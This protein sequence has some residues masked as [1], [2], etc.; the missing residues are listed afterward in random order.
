MKAGNVWRIKFFTAQSVAIVMLLRNT[1]DSYKNVAV[2]A[3]LCL[4][5]SCAK[6][7]PGPSGRLE[8]HS[9]ESQKWAGLRLAGPSSV[10]GGCAFA[11]KCSP[12]YLHQSPLLLADLLGTWQRGATY[13]PLDPTH[14]NDRNTLM[15]EDADDDFVLSETDVL[16]SAPRGSAKLLAAIDDW[17]ISSHQQRH[18]FAQS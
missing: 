5:S 13:L 1:S 12:I 14:P 16:P 17:G 6:K 7:A 8:K 4:G 9:L 3:V 11:P 18:W 10:I 2:P 15:V